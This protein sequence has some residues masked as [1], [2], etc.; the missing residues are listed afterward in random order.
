M[1]AMGHLSAAALH[2]QVTAPAISITIRGL[3]EHVQRVV[4]A[5][6]I[7]LP[8]TMEWDSFAQSKADSFVEL[9]GTSSS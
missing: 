9:S 3:P 5:F 4:D 7:A 1:S 8:G 6:E 2:V